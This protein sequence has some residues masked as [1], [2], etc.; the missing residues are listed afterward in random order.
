M[1]A[2]LD[3]LIGFEAQPAQPHL[4]LPQ[5]WARPFAEDAV[6]ILEVIFSRQKGVDRLTRF[7]R[8]L[9]RPEPGCLPDWLKPDRWLVRS[10][11]AG[12]QGQ[13]IILARTVDIE[14][15]GPKI[16]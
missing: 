10:D 11:R 6:D 15:R 1:L 5:L 7:E 2:V 16:N 3:N 14:A 4:E 9:D 13:P 12:G 8:K